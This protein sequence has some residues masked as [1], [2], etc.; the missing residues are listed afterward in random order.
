MELF[1]VVDFEEDVL[2]HVGIICIEDGRGG[3]RV[4]ASRLEE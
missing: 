4:Q 2:T 3:P 1:I